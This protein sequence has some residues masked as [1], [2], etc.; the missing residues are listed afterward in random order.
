VNV[1]VLICGRRINTICCGVDNMRPFYL[2][3]LLSM[4]QCCALECFELHIYYLIRCGVRMRYAFNGSVSE[5]REFNF[6]KC[7]VLFSEA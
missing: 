5:L 3:L 1:D 6:R 7:M 2:F 4:D